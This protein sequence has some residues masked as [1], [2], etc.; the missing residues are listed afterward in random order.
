[1]K[2]CF[3]LLFAVVLGWQSNTFGLALYF[4]DA[5]GTAPGAGGSTPTGTWGASPF[6]NTNAA[7]GGA[8]GPIAWPAG[9]Y[10]VFSAGNDANGAYTVL[11]S[12][13]VKVADIHVDL[14]QVT[15]NPAPVSG[16]S[17]QIL[18][19]FD[20]GAG[21]VLSVGHK[22]VNAVARYNV[23]LTSATNITRYKQGTVIFGATNTYYG[24][25]IIE[26][27]IL[28]IAV[29]NAIPTN[30]QLVLAN[31]DTTRGDFNPVWQYTPAVF[32]SGGLNQRLGTLKLS[33][34]DASV[35]RIIDFDFG[36]SAVSFA[37]S[38]AEDWG[39]F[40]LTLVNFKPGID[41]LR[42]GTSS[43]GLTAT[44]LGQMQFAEF[45]N[46]PGQ[47]SASGFVTPAIP[48]FTQ[49]NRSGT[50][51]NL[52]WTAVNGRTYHV[53]SKDSITQAGWDD[54]FPDVTASGDTASF[55]D[56]NATV[57]QRYY[58]LIVQP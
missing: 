17:L 52:T 23:P 14:G 21:R 44:Q 36:N 37:N 45:N 13:T 12:N 24:S 46:L 2:R 9:N 32:N 33:G 54:Q 18:D 4:W 3:P 34:T 40:T 48:V 35:Q 43:A 8:T 57:T 20:V 10:A 53:Q 31:N 30:S 11:V 42:F 7:G 51:V 47:I 22:D 39:G 19:G 25:T 1:M 41:S 29:P 16:G 56:S 27:G 38:S 50:T 49:I 26:G 6:W 55:M 28:Q 15:F 5:N 58:R